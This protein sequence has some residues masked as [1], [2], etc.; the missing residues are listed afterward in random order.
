[1]PR[2]ETKPIHHLV[3]AG[4][5]IFV[6]KT[7]RTDH[8]HAFR[9]QLDETQPKSKYIL[10]A[11]TAAESHQWQQALLKHAPLSPV[12]VPKPGT[13]L[14]AGALLAS[15]APPTAPALGSA[16]TERA[17]TGGAA[18]AKRK[19]MILGSSG[20]VGQ[21]TIHWLLQ[22]HSSACEIQVGT[23][24][25]KR[26]A[27]TAG[28][29][30]VAANIHNPQ[31][32]WLRPL[33]S[34]VLITPSNDQRVPSTIKMCTAATRAGIKHIVV[35]SVI[36]AERNDTVFGQQF[37]QIEGA[38]K[39][40]CATCSTRYTIVRLPLF[41][42]NYYGFT[43]SVK[44]EG[45]VRCSMDPTQRYSPIA[46]SDV[47]EALA[48]IAADSGGR[49]H[50][51]TLDMAGEAHSCAEMVAW[52]GAARSAPVAYEKVSADAALETLLKCGFLRWQAEGLVQLYEL[53]SQGEYQYST[54]TLKQVIGHEPLS[55]REWLRSAAPAFATAAAPSS[56]VPETPMPTPAPPAPSTALPAPHTVATA[57]PPAAPERSAVKTWPHHQRI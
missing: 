53:I 10:A 17:A 33:D 44:A 39:E 49:Y 42:E 46:V 21:A 25:P 34:L 55:V 32:A 23:R 26:L 12:D 4:C 48:A 22:R 18:E 47:G 50:N 7:N 27:Q 38:I 40:L 28:V 54:S 29:V 14:A 24:D 45:I 37:Q 8:E 15:N 13:A 1:M 43:E 19:V 31:D 3:L 16:T 11:D 41:L 51:K 6:P 57:P 30:P 35:V 52:L 20:S 9:L 56:A 2:P 5:A 36:T